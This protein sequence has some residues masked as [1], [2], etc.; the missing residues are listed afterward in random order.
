MSAIDWLSSSVVTPAAAPGYT[1]GALLNPIPGE[2]PVSSGAALE[3]ISVTPLDRPNPSAP[4]LLP[5][6]RTGLPRGLWG[7]TPEA[8]LA[9]L[10]RKERLDT[11]P[12]IQ[13]LLVTLLLAEIDP[14]RIGAPAPADSLFLARI[15]RLLDLGA[16]EPA[17]ALL[18]LAG[19]N[20]AETFRRLF[21]VALLLGEETRACAALK[22]TP[23]IAPAIAARIYCLA[24]GGDWSAAALSLQTARALG[25][26]DAETAALLERFLD[27]EMAEEAEDLPPPARPSPLVL[28]ML[29]AIGQPLPTT[30]LPV[31]F[32]QADMRSNTGW[33]ARIE[34][35]ERLARMGSIDPNQLLGLYTETRAAASGGVWDRVSAVT[36][37]DVAV[38]ARDVA[39]VSTT[40]PRA[41]DAMARQELEVQLATLFAEPLAALDLSGEAAT[42]A[43]HLGLLSEH[44]EAA[45]RSRRPQDADERL[46]IGIA[47]GTTAGIAASDSLGLAIKRVFDAPPDAPPTYA[48]LLPADRLGEALL[49]AIDDV[50]EGAKGDYQ[51]VSAGLALLRHVGLETIA[52]RAALELIVLE[53]RG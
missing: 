50:T 35:A 52:R 4:G 23:G 1:P 26:I 31:A 49:R 32:A 44:Y 7:A 27:P 13:S 45:A 37:L 18:E 42:L 41:Y 10:L 34:A 24:R 48:D 6:S 30:T 9:R 17:F 20:D 46:L 16:L 28:R 22:E 29:E 8:D 14:P 39:A 43:F 19:A 2:A 3:S 47:Q 38:T 11:L 51:R 21:D 33:K 5:V 25:Q 53:R 15:D 12:A 36:A 40:L